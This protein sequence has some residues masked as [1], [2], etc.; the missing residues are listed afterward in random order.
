MFNSMRRLGRLFG[1]FFVRCRPLFVSSL[2]LAALLTP[3]SAVI[4]IA[5]DIEQLPTLEEMQ[6][7]SEDELLK[8]YEDDKPFDWIVLKERNAVVVVAEVIPRP[9]PLEEIERRRQRIENSNPRNQAERIKRREELDRLEYLTVTLRDNAFDDF[10][11]AVKHVEQVILFEDL[12]L[13]RADKLIEEGSV[14]NAYDMITMVQKTSG[15]ENW[16]KIPPRFEALL[17]AE[18][19]IRAQEGDAYAALALLDELSQRNREHPQLQERYGELLTPMV[20]M[21]VGDQDYGKARYLIG[22]LAKYFPQHVK[23]GEWR[24]QLQGKADALLQQGVQLTDGREFAAAAE[25]AREAEGIWPSTGNSRTVYTRL[26]S[27][28]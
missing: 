25:K 9:D 21:A 28:H 3:G 15:F 13:Q 20:E 7:P 18:A 26:V 6:L 8:A 1:A 11:I 17:L 24:G 16:E 2:L 27:R 12:M 22:R 4:S 19:R 5:Q 14:G 10:K 23:V